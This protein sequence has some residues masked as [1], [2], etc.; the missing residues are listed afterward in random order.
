MDHL[1]CA[2][3]MS[4]G[5]DSS[6]TAMILKG[7]GHRPLG[8]TLLMSP[9]SSECSRSVQLARRTA[10]ILGI[11]HTVLDLRDLFRRH[12][13]DKFRTEYMAGRTPNPCSDCNR[14][15]KLGGL[16]ERLDRMGLDGIPMATG[17]YARIL[18]DPAGA[19]LVMGLDH[20]RDQSYFLAEVPKGII[21][22]LMFP[23][24]GMTKEQVR[25]LAEE[26]RLPARRE[27]DSMDSCFVEDGDYREVIGP[28]ID[29]QGPIVDLR[30][31]VLGIHQGF[32]RFT[33]GQR[34]GLGVSS[35]EALY[36]KR[37]DPP[38]VVVAPRD[39]LMERH[40]TASGGNWLEEGDLR[41]GAQLLG[42][43]RSQGRPSPCTVEEVEGDRIR[44]LFHGEGVF[45]PCPGQ[46]LVLYRPDGVVVG[47]ATMD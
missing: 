28:V 35:T 6:V 17:H 42:K 45:A 9:S 40:V 7:E 34:K 18:K 33:V 26:A 36:V 29:S 31:N 3:L 41:C 20:R 44:V 16:A 24:G 47:C 11:R 30:G 37:I 1:T 21:R 22:R 46:R 2:V 5:V 8:V 25:L 14:N 38:T 27:A 23:L 4:G 13:M 43:T 39:R 19:H 32:H 12:V 10:E 15:V